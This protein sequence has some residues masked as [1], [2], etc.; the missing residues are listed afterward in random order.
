MDVV[1]HVIRIHPQAC[2]IIHHDAVA[3]IMLINKVEIVNFG[4]KK[5]GNV[6]DDRSQ[7][8]W[9]QVGHHSSS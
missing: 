7:K 3:I 4:L 2:H 1:V 6:E 9:H 5:L 8:S